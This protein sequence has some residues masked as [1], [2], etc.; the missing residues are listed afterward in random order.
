MA[1]HHLPPYPPRH[2]QIRSAL[3]VAGIVSSMVAVI[4]YLFTN[5]ATLVAD[6]IC[7]RGSLVSIRGFEYYGSPSVRYIVELDDGELIE[8]ARRGYPFRKGA[9]VFL[10]R[11]VHKSG[12]TARYQIDRFAE[13]N[14]S[15]SV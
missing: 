8:A 1:K 13:P 10:T 12:R 14:E 5:P 9:A 4:W 6:S 3:F 2:Q 11:L 7:V 15:C